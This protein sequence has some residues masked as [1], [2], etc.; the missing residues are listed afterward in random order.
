M[1]IP[2]TGQPRIARI[3]RWIGFAL[4][5]YWSTL[6]VSTHIPIPK[7]MLPPGVS[8]KTMHYVA[9]AGLGFLLTVWRST[10]RHLPLKSLVSILLCISVYG[11]ID[12]LLQIPVGR[13][14]D[15]L[16]WIADFCGAV[17][18]IASFAA[19]RSLFPGPWRSAGL[20]G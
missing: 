7:D 6:F 14:A 3:R 10:K 16:D 12:E 8:D 19:C 17:L 15:V 18:G 1:P 4:F 11:I 5:V 20:R 9:Y 2:T 13:H